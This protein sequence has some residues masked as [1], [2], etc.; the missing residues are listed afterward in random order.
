VSPDLIAKILDLCDFADDWLDDKVSLDRDVRTL[1]AE[2]RTALE[3]AQEEAPCP[4]VWEGDTLR[5]GV[6]NAGRV[7]RFKGW[8]AAG[9]S[10]G[11][12]IVMTDEF[13]ARAVVV[14]LAG[15]DPGVTFALSLHPDWTRE[16]IDAARAWGLGSY[17][18]GMLE[19]YAEDF[20]GQQHEDD[21]QIARRWWAGGYKALTIQA[22]ERSDDNPF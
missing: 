17:V 15:F 8:W 12:T 11:K 1:A 19:G 9:D 6:L 3:P 7:G 22:K 13:T 5:V 14:A 2:I 10:D 20:N 16:D 4:W 21:P 18:A